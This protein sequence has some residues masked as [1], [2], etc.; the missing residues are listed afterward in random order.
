MRRLLTADRNSI[1][2]SVKLTWYS[3]VKLEKLAESL[4]YS[5]FYQL[6]AVD[7]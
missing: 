7:N 4:N 2:I 3:R 5:D 1:K 6:L